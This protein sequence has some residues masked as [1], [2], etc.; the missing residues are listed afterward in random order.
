MRLFKNYNNLDLLFYQVK[1]I[2][3]ENISGILI[4]SAIPFVLLIR[5][6]RPIAHIKFCGFSS[7]R[8]GHFT[9]DSGIMLV[10]NVLKKDNIFNWYYVE[11]Y[12]TTNKQFYKMVKRTFF[13]RWWVKYL[14]LAN[15]LIPGGEIHKGRGAPRLTQFSRDIKGILHKT[16]SND[17]TYF[18][19]TDKEVLKAKEKLRSVG[20]KDGEKF[21][22]ILVRD[23]SYSIKINNNSKNIQKFNNNIDKTI[24]FTRDY[25]RNSD[26]GTYSEA[27]NE[28]ADRGYWGFRLGKNVNKG[29]STSHKR[30]VDYALSEIRCDLLDIWLSANCYFFVSTATGLE[31]V[32]DIFRR[33]IVN[34]NNLPLTLF[35][36]WGYTL[37]APKHLF[38]RKDNTRL[39][40][41]EHLASYNDYYSNKII[42]KDLSSSEIKDTVIE[43]DERLSGRWIDN[44]SNIK[45]MEMFWDS[46]KRSAIKKHRNNFINKNARLSRAFLNSSGNS[47]LSNN[48]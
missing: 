35:L 22:C 20:W 39:N 30:I 47:F 42:I 43:M 16:K 2:F 10:E 28:L 23:E 44:D 34:V 18:K 31:S 41:D 40:S 12:Y 14:D 45:E 32:A 37:T 4:I 9:A 26:I 21:I 24:D 36:T 29:I 3:I 15:N 48:K 5:L 27:M 46:Y 6:F 19:F 17:D 25:Y 8:V 7:R 11:K 33:P 13:V 1:R 38:W